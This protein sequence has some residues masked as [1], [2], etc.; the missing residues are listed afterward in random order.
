MDKEFEN[1][2]S[3]KINSSAEY[4]N[5][6]DVLASTKEDNALVCFLGAGTSISQGYKDWNGYV[7]DLIQY[8]KTHLQDLLGE[9][10]LSS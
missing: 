3:T 10:S 9:N 8:W 1:L 6:I 2:V 4:N 5:F 7:Q